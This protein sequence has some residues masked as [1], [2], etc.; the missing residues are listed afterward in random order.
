MV[1]RLAMTVPVLDHFDPARQPLMTRPAYRRELVAAGTVPFGL[2]ML[3]GG[4]VGVVSKTIFEVGNFGFAAIFA[5]PM[6][7]N[8]TSLFWSRLARGKSKVGVTAALMSAVLLLVASVALLPTSGWG[9]GALVTTVVFGRVLVAGIITVRSTIWRANYPRALRAQVTGRF[10]LLA[11]LILA[12]WPMAVGPLLDRDASLFRVLYPLTAL[13]GAVGVVSFARMR[14][15]GERRLRQ[16]ESEPYTADAPLQPNGK[17]HNAVSVLRHDRTFRW[18]MVWQFV[19]GVANMAGTTAFALFVINRLDGVAWENA[20]G[21]LLNASLPLGLAVLSMPWWARRLDVLHIT[22]YRVIHGTT[23]IV[24]QS[25]NFVAAFFGWLPLLYLA[26]GTHGLVRGG[27][28][29]AWQLGHN[30][31]ADRRLVSLY[32][33]IHQTL[34][35]LRG[36]FAPFLG[37]LLLAGWDSFELAG[38][39]VG[40]WGGI[41]A[42][43][44]AVTTGLAFVAWLG[45]FGLNRKLREE[46][47][48]A[49]V[50]AG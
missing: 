35:G 28:M 18:Y 11:S 13:I 49:A 31:F 25:L 43:V 39:G 40:G 47:R 45:F 2:A 15:R 46:G 6:F 17:P 21:M 1:A 34:T 8:V 14:V 7:A 10:V 29:L 20:Q 32:M 9:A 44:F 33:G 22:R 3:E 23:W 16:E 50:D 42:G 24:N 26:S 38:Y 5:A 12:V 37:T 48:D 4:V 41:G 19:A 27:G 30:D 36:A